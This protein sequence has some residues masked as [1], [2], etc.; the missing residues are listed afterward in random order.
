MVPVK[1]YVLK[2]QRWELV[3]KRFKVD[4]FSMDKKGKRKPNGISFVIEKQ[5]V[6]PARK[7][8][9]H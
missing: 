8:R 5:E 6:R 4:G 9:R 3:L 1:G 7:K 2:A